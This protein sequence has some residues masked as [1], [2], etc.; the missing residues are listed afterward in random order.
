MCYAHR[1]TC[2][3]VTEKIMV[4]SPIGGSNPA[5]C[6]LNGR[7]DVSRMFCCLYSPKHLKTDPR[8][9]TRPANRRDNITVGCMC[10]IGTNIRERRLDSTGGTV[11]LL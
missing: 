10:Q 8:T 1:G 2:H 4:W 11:T 7:M 9:A 6:V 5:R 3:V